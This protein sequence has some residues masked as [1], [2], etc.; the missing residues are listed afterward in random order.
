MFSTISREG[1]TKYVPVKQ[2]FIKKTIDSKLWETCE[3]LQPNRNTV[4]GTQA[5][6]SQ[7]ILLSP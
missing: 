6:K 1:Q 7:V 4:E 2:K 5:G 3:L